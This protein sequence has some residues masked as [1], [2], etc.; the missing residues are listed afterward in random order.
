MN[1]KPFVTTEL[2]PIEQQFEKLRDNIDLDKINKELVDYAAQVQRLREQIE[3]LQYEVEAISGI[4][5]ER[6]DFSARYETASR[7][8]TSLS[9]ALANA[10]KERDAL[11]AELARPESTVVSLMRA[12]NAALKDAARLALDA[13]E[14]LHTIDTETEIVTIWVEDEIAALKAVL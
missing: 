6:D 11:K 2:K 10:L 4:K 3:T 5:A 13:L 12:E 7:L 8:V 1:H 14:Q 9:D